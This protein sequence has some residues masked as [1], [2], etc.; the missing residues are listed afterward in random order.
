MNIIKP[1]AEPTSEMW[2]DPN[3][4]M[5]DCGDW[6]A[7]EVT[8]QDILE[9]KFGIIENFWHSGDKLIQMGWTKVTANYIMYQHYCAAGIYKNC[10]NEQWKVIS[11]WKERFL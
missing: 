6:G 1:I 2:I 8:A 10:T 4:V 11:L 3:G 5:Y 9:Q 7:H